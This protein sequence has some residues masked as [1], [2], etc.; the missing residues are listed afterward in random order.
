MKKEPV[1]QRYT[2]RDG[3]CSA[4]QHGRDRKANGNKSY[5]WRRPQ[6]KITNLAALELLTGIAYP[7]ARGVIEPFHVLR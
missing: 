7:E 2:R 6:L 3:Q 4:L 5:T 1:V